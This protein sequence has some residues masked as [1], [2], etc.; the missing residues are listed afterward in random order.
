MA[1]SLP[2][3]WQF[4]L[5]PEF[6]QPYWIELMSFVSREYREHIC[7]PESKDIFKAFVMTPF[8]GVKVVILGQDPY[9]TIGAAMWLAFSIPEDSK[10]QPSLRNIF[11]ELESDIWIK[12]INTDLTDWARQ[13]ILLLNT[14]L[15]VREWAPASHQGMGWEQFT[16]ATMIALSEHREG[17]VF[18]LWGNY[19]IA[20]QSLIDTTRHHIII[21]AHPSPFSAHRGFLGSRPFSR[22]NEYL[23]QSWKIEIKWN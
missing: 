8:E 22:T 11:R 14:V 15:T 19:A 1:I 3:S 23:R 7:F 13:W 5:A 6:S 9:H 2:P 4:E 12:R 16:D 20:K 18:I 17:L 10:P 21:S